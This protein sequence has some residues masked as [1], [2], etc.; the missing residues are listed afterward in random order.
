MTFME[1]MSIVL[2]RWPDGHRMF[3]TSKKE[4]GPEFAMT[5]E[6]LD[7]YNE[8]VTVP[9][10]TLL[11]ERQHDVLR[12]TGDPLKPEDVEAED[13]DVDSIPF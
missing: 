13:W 8:T 3:R 11:V 4:R 5:S 6:P 9:G 1:A 7:G 2:C 12:L 10:A